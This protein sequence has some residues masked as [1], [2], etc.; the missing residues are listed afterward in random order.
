LRNQS[1]VF[2]AF[3]AFLLR[4]FWF[5]RRA[6]WLKLQLESKSDSHGDSARTLKAQGQG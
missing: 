6:K 5:L 2:V 3:E 1:A 4:R